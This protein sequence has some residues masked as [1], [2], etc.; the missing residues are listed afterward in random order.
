MGLEIQKLQ[1]TGDDFSAMVSFDNDFFI[2]ATEIYVAAGKPQTTFVSFKNRTLI[3]RAQKLIEMG[4]IQPSQNAMVDVN[5]PITV[6]D[7]IITRSGQHGGGT[8]IHPKLRMVFTRWIS[9]DFDIWCDMKVEELFTKGYT[10]LNQEVTDEITKSMAYNPT[11]RGAVGKLKK[12]RNLHI[13]PFIIDGIKYTIED[14]VSFDDFLR[15]VMSATDYGSKELVYGKVLKS[16]DISLM[17]N[18]ITIGQY[19]DMKNTTEIAHKALLRRRVSSKDKKILA[20]TSTICDLG[21]QLADS[22]NK[23]EVEQLSL[24]IAT[25]SE[26][27][28]KLRRVVTAYQQSENA[29]AFNLKSITPYNAFVESKRIADLIEKDD[30]SLLFFHGVVVPPRN[31]GM[32]VSADG[33]QLVPH[34]AGNAIPNYDLSIWRETK[35]K[36]VSFRI[37]KGWK[38][39]MVV[40]IY[41]QLERVP[42][43]NTLWLGY[44][45]DEYG[46][47]YRIAFEET[48]DTLL[49][50]KEL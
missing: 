19:T 30:K 36:G 41:T 25:V 17:K 39:D 3:P 4:A 40:I 42:G 13:M 28:D 15:T 10:G 8:W 14:G 46:T 37:S 34:L 11:L 24:E 2:N 6:D 7:L 23:E 33:K 22:T 35:D 20:L 16:L 18:F 48:S 9:E 31:A 49:V 45:K 44:K 12:K 38:R 27:R 5:T 26:E 43:N 21:K 32:A 29:P 1:Y 50:Y 47:F